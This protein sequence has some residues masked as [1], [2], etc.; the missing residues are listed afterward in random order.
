[1][2]VRSWTCWSPFAILFGLLSASLSVFM[3]SVTVMNG[4]DGAICGRARGLAR[5]A[6]VLTIV[7]FAVEWSLG[8]RHAGLCFDQQPE[9]GMAETPSPAGEVGLGRRCLVRRLPRPRATVAVARAGFARH[10][11]RLVCPRLQGARTWLG[12]WARWLLD[13]C[14]RHGRCRAFPFLLPSS[15]VP[16]AEPDFRS[17]LPAPVGFALTWMRALRSGLR[18][19]DPWYASWASMW[20]PRKGQGRARRPLTNTLTAGQP[21]RPSAACSCCSC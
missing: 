7:L 11:A 10:A 12:G 18:P 13:R 19:V 1:M 14:S 15:S 6:S 16:R 4:A 2:P 3:G 9:H 8:A 5:V 17:G 20:C 21:W